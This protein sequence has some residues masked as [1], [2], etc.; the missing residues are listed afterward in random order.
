MLDRWT[1]GAAGVVS[2]LL[3]G[4]V[5]TLQSTVRLNEGNQAVAAHQQVMERLDAVRRSFHQA[6]T[7]QRDFLI[8]GGITVPA[9]IGSNF[10][11]GRAELEL[12]QSQVFPDVQQLKRVELIDSSAQ[13]LE[14]LLRYTADVRAREG[15]EAA[16]SVIES[17]V[18]QQL[19][20]TIDDTIQSMESEERA[21][22]SKRLRTTASTFR[23]TMIVGI[24]SGIVAIGGQMSFVWLLRRHLTNQ[25]LQTRQIAAQREQ[26]R[27]TL[28]SIGD[29]LITTD[30]SL[31]VTGLNSVA[32]RLTGWTQTEVLGKHLSEVFRIVRQDSGESLVDPAQQS[33]ETERVVHSA[34]ATKLVTRQMNEIPIDSNAAPIRSDNGTITGCILVFRD[35]SARRALEQEIAERLADARLLAAIVESSRDPIVSKSIDGV[36]R[37]WN[38]AAERLFGYSADEVIGRHIAFLIPPDRMHEE[39]EIIR[40]LSSGERIEELETVRRRADGT[41]VEVSLTVSPL[42]DR[43][44]QVIGASKTVRDITERKLAERALRES[45]AKFRNLADNMSQFAWM[46]D[47]KG[48]IFW[49]NRRWYD[50]TGTTLEEMQGWGWKAVHHPDHVDRVVSKIQQAWDTGQIWEDTFPLRGKDGEYRWFLSRAIPI[51]DASGE[52]TVWLGT[53]TDVTERMEAERALRE[54]DQR[55][56]EFLAMLAHELRN[57][58]APIRHGLEVLSR[59]RR[60]DEAAVELMKSQANQLVRL[61]DDLLNVSR[62]MRGKVRLHV[63][64]IETRSLLEGALAKLRPTLEDRRQT[65]DVELPAEPVWIAGDRV[66][67]TQVFDNLLG[68]ASKYSDQGGRIEL[69]VRVADEVIEIVVSDDGVGIDGELIDKVFDLFTQAEQPLDR[70]QGGLGIGLTIVRQLVERHRGQVRVESPGLGQGSTFRVRLPRPTRDELD[71]LLP[72][73]ESQ[74]AKVEPTSRR[75]LVVD[76][77]QGAAGMLS[78]LLRKLGDHQVETAHDANDALARIEREPPDIAFFDIG[79]P[80]I[81]GYELARRV[82]QLVVGKRIHL[83]ALTGY[84]QDSDREQALAAGFDRHVVKPASYEILEAILNGDSP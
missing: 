74:E 19:M 69:S 63:E 49:Y 70:S 43:N 31:R 39:A 60:F 51:R 6:E 50:Y 48:W 10:A 42:I 80:G 65:V 9:E 5:L 71:E 68:N 47:S 52:I 17:D 12:V 54:S 14:D 37:S 25:A 33:M 76:D 66:R 23:W 62:I 44:G 13:Q 7:T 11:T 20:A 15:F 79:L 1:M 32:E 28:E 30:Q 38:R 22:L 4:I 29:A 75:V 73:T 40:R 24:L 36:I 21:Q 41:L 58:L 45:E 18:S 82:R 57:P 64:A 35:I 8:V 2:L 3:L 59:E 81:D 78:R 16:R 26:L 83:V 67:L 34:D 61:V 46:A 53:N 77:N 55:K 56:N 84:G 72:E 27:V